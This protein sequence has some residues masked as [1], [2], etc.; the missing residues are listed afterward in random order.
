VT[1]HR[2]ICSLSLLNAIAAGA[3]DKMA[4]AQ[5]GPPEVVVCLPL[6]AGPGTNTVRVRGINLTN[7]TGIRF[8]QAVTGLEA[9]IKSKGAAKIPDKQE[10][11]Q[12]GD[13]ELEVQ[14]RIPPGLTNELIQFSVVTPLTNSAPHSLRILPSAIHVPERE[15]NGG[16][17]AAQEL[18]LPAMVDGGIEKPLDVDV[19]SFMA[20]AGKRIR[21]EIIAARLGSPLDSLVTLFDEQGHSLSTNDD[22]V[23]R[24]SVLDVKLPAAGRYFLSVQDANDLGGP[25]HA[26]LLDVRWVD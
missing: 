21:A 9:V 25:V 23:G 12:V 18:K 4:P 16:F 13:T 8:S 15:P 14:L 17:R 11:K 22:S 5:V 7:A 6:G 26:Y 3:A 20:P 1:F 10:A 19:Y 24:D 2:L